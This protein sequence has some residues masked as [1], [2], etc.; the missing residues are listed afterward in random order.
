MFY[1]DHP[2]NTARVRGMLPRDKAE[3]IELLDETIERYDNDFLDSV[4]QRSSL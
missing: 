3:L 2:L 1:G 4:A